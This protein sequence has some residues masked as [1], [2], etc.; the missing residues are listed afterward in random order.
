MCVCGG[1]SERRPRRSESKN[2]K[3]TKVSRKRQG[4][5]GVLREGQRPAE[6]SICTSLGIKDGGRDAVGLGEN[7]GGAV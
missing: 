4:P 6:S 7:G 5:E 3:K 2:E 1:G